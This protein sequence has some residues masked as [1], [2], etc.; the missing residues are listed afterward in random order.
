[1]SLAILQDNLLE[2]LQDFHVLTGIRI[3]LFDDRHQEILTY[4]NEH[5]SLCSLIRRDPAG[6]AQCEICDRHAFEECRQRGQLVMYKCHAGLIEATAPIKA[7]GV[8]IGYFMFGQ[9]TQETDREA[10]AGMALER[11][12]GDGQMQEEWTR[13]AA[14]VPNRTHRQIQAAAKILEACTYYVIQ[15]ELV[16][17]RH[18]RLIDL[19]NRYIDENLPERL[20]VEDLAAHFQ[21]S[22]TVLYDLMNN[23]LGM[24]IAEYVRRKRMEKA[25]EFLATTEMTATQI[26]ARVGFTDYG[27][28]MKVFK[29]TYG[30]T[31]KAYREKFVQSLPHT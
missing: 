29:K 4:P 14:N 8:V 25:R 22:R 3:V 18:E 6:L 13:A 17:I 31:M 9:V 21:I 27:Y 28:F 7:N 11:F 5:S 24:G 15:K 2:L 10:L 12:P 23:T 20:S 30:I 19:M 26:S 1:M 16:S